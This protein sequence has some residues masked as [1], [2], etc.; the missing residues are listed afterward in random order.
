MPPPVPRRRNRLSPG[1]ADHNHIGVPGRQ[2]FEPGGVCS[3]FGSD[4]CGGGGREGGTASD[5]VRGASAAG[6]AR[7]VFIWPFGG[8][9]GGGSAA[10]WALRFPQRG[11]S[12][13][14]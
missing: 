13:E 5:A 2:D 4:S 6:F 3:C 7:S 10:F 11:I 8:T 12:A 9:G 14:L 1:P